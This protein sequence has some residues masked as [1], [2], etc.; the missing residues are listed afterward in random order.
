M[1]LLFFHRDPDLAVVVLVLGAVLKLAG[2]AVQLHID[3]GSDL[4]VGVRGQPLG[5]DLLVQSLEGL[6]PPAGAGEHRPGVGRDGTG[7]EAVRDLL[8]GIVVVG[9]EIFKLV[10]AILSSRLMPYMPHTTL[11]PPVPKCSA[12]NWG[13]C[14]AASSYWK[15]FARQSTV[16]APFFIIFQ[17]MF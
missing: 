10:A 1:A 3:A 6:G 11:P 16:N 2:V 17:S 7:G 13:T 15:V 4:V 9:E 5:K 14:A 12:Q 8:G